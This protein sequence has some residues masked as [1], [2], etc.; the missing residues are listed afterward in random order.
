MTRML[1][2]LKLASVL[3]PIAPARCRQEIFAFD[4]AHNP[5]RGL[6]GDVPRSGGVSHP[7]ELPFEIFLPLLFRGCGSGEPLRLCRNPS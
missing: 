2:H 4:Q 7:C 3:P 6:V 5:W 1:R